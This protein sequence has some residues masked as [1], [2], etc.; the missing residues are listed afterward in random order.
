MQINSTNYKSSE[1]NYITEGGL[2]LL[3]L[4][5]WE[6][7]GMSQNG[8]EKIKVTCEAKKIN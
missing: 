5:K 2:Y 4:N 8:E 1:I 3:K 7:D 6:L